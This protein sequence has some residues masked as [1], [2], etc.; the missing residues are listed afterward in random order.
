MVD[1]PVQASALAS[2]V[3]SAKNG[4]AASLEWSVVT[5]D[6]VLSRRLCAALRPGEGILY[7]DA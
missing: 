4:T 3:S 7:T 5:R 1:E 6:S 2:I